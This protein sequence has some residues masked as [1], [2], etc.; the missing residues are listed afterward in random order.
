MSAPPEP[1]VLMARRQTLS[2][3]TWI[4][5]GAVVVFWLAIIVFALLNT[6]ADQL[7]TVLPSLLIPVGMCAIFVPLVLWMRKASVRRLLPERLVIGPDRITLVQRRGTGREWRKAD[8][9][10]VRAVG[11]NQK[12]Q[13]RIGTDNL[14]ITALHAR[15]FDMDDIRA[16]CI[17]HGWSWQEGRGEVFQ[18][19]P[20]DVRREYDGEAAPTPSTPPDTALLLREGK[21]AMPKNARLVYIAM[22]VAWLAVVIGMTTMDVVTN[23][24]TFGGLHPFV[25]A[26]VLIVAIIVY[27]WAVVRKLRVR[28]LVNPQRLAVEYGSR[29][30]TAQREAVDLVTLSAKR[31]VMH[32]GGRRVLA[33]GHQGHAEEL[34][35]VLIAN[36]WPA[37]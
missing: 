23:D 34:R 5:L 10:L 35:A 12:R 21:T 17:E 25:F 18:A 20:Q 32:G 24:R 26:P 28:V 8:G 2:A 15:L 16:A 13:I 3:A 27:T 37:G 6:P 4:F 14:G 36:G 31:L 22:S 1:T 33:V 7:G 9:D 29:T 30:V 19:V 11:R